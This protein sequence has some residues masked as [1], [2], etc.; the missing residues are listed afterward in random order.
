MATKTS[1]LLFYLTLSRSRKV[2][3]WL[4]LG[5]LAVVNVAGL[6][7]TILNI[8]QCRPVHA[9]FQT[10]VPESA[11]CTDI[12]SIYLSSA[13]VNFATDV[14]ILFLPM[15]ILTSMRLP[16][17]Q[18]IILIITFS[19]GVF[20]AVVD[21]V[22]IAYLQ[23][24][25][26]AR[27]REIEEHNDSDGESRNISDLSWNLAMSLMW[28]AVEVNV[29]IM[30]ACVPSLKPLV[31]RFLPHWIRDVGDAETFISK[32]SGGS[33]ELG[34]NHRIPSVPSVMLRSPQR[35][36]VSSNASGPMPLS[37][38]APMDMM[39]FL[40]TPD[41]N[42]S[43]ALNRRDTMLTAATAS[44]R[45]TSTSSPAFFDFVNFKRKKSMVYM[46]NRESIF[47]VMM[48][49]VLFFMWGFAYGLLDTLNA[50]F[51]VVAHVTAS[52]SM[53]NHCA[54]FAGYFIAPVTFGRLV[55][56]KWGFKACY[57]VGLT[58][59]ACGTLVFW[60]SAVLNSFPAFIISNFIVGLGLSVLEIAANPFI[61]LCGP[62][63]YGEIRLN[64][65]QGLQ[66]IGTVCS[67]L[68]AKKALFGNRTAESLIDIQ[69]TYLGIAIFTLFCAL[70]YYYVPLPE[71]TDEELEDVA[72]RFDNA[73][74]ARVG[75]VRVIWVTLS[76]GVFAMFCYGAGQESVSTSFA[77]YITAVA[78]WLDPTNHQAIGHSVFA[79][80]RF[81]AAGLN[82]IFKPR[83]I[84]LVSVAATIA[85]SAVSMNFYGATPAA[86]VIMVYL[87][88][89]PIFSLIY[90]QSLRGLGRHTKE[91]SVALTAAIC[92]GAVLPPVMQTIGNVR[93]FQYAF[94]I[95]LAGFAAVSVFPLYL[96]LVPK[97]KKQVDPVNM[98]DMSL[99]RSDS[100]GPSLK[101]ASPVGD[102]S[103]GIPNPQEPEPKATTD[104]DPEASLTQSISPPS[105]ATPTNE[106]PQ[107]NGSPKKLSWGED[108]G[109][110]I[111]KDFG[112]LPAAEFREVKSVPGSGAVRW[113]P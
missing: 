75:G 98:R 109:T 101:T 57:T 14:A 104:T 42:D 85:F 39:E 86:S 108:P 106:K 54:Y 99:D 36:R 72:E 15:P 21:I 96:N 92:G 32:H 45:P 61:V 110:P 41:M 58:I 18:K 76:L 17:K 27:F 49:T 55:L 79:I 103:A 37:P 24:A 6:A 91:G 105:P 67:P 52:Q 40:T 78:P 51:Q 5:T 87:F 83:W 13:P 43:A 80:S 34:S 89:G 11:R 60:P 26:R 90:A 46:T 12:V 25:A 74:L 7:L 64:I 102:T 65:S 97:A 23:S 44:T 73:N 19:A 70:G 31:S 29:G 53:G 88:E 71:A 2:F 10:P 33:D 62:P 111:S 95:P 3:R 9:V 66:A 35:A 94:C 38:G 68:L 77:K 100:H 4:T 113:A 20:V 107:V 16:Q 22:R 47:P 81:A 1:I 48:V 63:E 30:C 112:N 59:Y 69:W 82:L 93:G 84:L 28:S 8:A 50:Q 56:R